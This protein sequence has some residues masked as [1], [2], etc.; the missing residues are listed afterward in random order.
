MK[1]AITGASGLLGSNLANFYSDRGHEVYILVKDE[2]YS[3][4][5]NENLNRIYGNVSV[6]SD[7]DYFV[8]KS[9][10]DYFIHLA[11]QTQAYDSLKYPYNTFY[12]NFV[13]T[14]NVLE[15]LREYKKCKS[16][17]VASSDKAYGELDGLEY[18]ESH[19]LDGIY[20][21]DASKS[22]TDLVSRSYR[23]TYGMPVV[24][25]RACNMYGVGDS[26]YQRLIPGIVKAFIEESVF[27]IRNGG[28]DIREYIH[29]QD[30][31]EAYDEILKFN[32]LPHDIDSFNISSGERHST[33]DVFNMV[34]EAIGKNIDNI[35]IDRESLEIKKQ[36]MNSSLLKDK[37]GW[38]SRRTLDSSLKEVVDWYIKSL[39][40]I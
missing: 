31:V 6:K 20:P 30:V 33:I 27:E 26:N 34:Q 15:S 38:F 36:F 24:S 12:I 11:A 28:K 35:I 7:V 37:T 40:I 18:T 17:V 3:V 2:F 9:S 1:I 25:T 13:G 21:Y 39:S 32:E 29:V 10:P 19:R 5:L 14:L 22:A 23:R 16:I 8:Q 4:N